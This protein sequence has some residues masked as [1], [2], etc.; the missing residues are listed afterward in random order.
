[1]MKMAPSVATLPICTSF[2]HDSVNS[3]PSS[4]D[5]AINVALKRQTDTLVDGVQ[6]Y[7]KAQ[8]HPVELRPK[9]EHALVSTRPTKCVL[10]TLN[11]FSFSVGG[12][13]IVMSI[14]SKGCDVPFAGVWDSA[15]VEVGAAAANAAGTL[16]CGL[17]F[18]CGGS[19]RQ[20]RSERTGK[21]QAR[22]W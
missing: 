19:I 15:G 9:A 5:H 12:W 14:L 18:G 20:I 1:M 21:T 10:L 7:E 3:R 4:S 13:R 2:A 8:T 6:E 11:L 16:S 17:N 22:R